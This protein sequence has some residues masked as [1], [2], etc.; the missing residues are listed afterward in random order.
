MKCLLF[1][2]LLSATLSASSIPDGAWNGKLWRKSDLLAGVEKGD[3]DAL[4]EWAFCA[5]RGL[6]ELPYD[7]KLIYQRA[8]KA[9]DLGSMAGKR[10]AAKC[11]MFG[12]GVGLDSKT[13]FRGI[14]RA[15]AQDCPDA[16]VDMALLH[17]KGEFGAQKDQAKAEALLRK[18]EK[19]GSF[20]AVDALSE[21]TSMKEYGGYDLAESRRLLAKAFGM[22]KDVYIAKK[23]YYAVVYSNREDYG[24]IITRRMFSE[25][26]EVIEQGIL[27]HH[28][29]ALFT[30]SFY[31]LDSPNGDRH[32]GVM[33]Q[34]RAANLGNKAAMKNMTRWLARGVKKR[35]AGE[36]QTLAVGN[37][38]DSLKTAKYAYDRGERSNSVIYVYASQLSSATGEGC[39]EKHRLAE[40]LLKKLI[41]NG[42]CNAHDVLGNLRLRRHEKFNGSKE[43]A[44][45]GLAHMVYH[46]N[47]SEY[48]VYGL[49]Y[50]LCMHKEMASYDLV[51]GA[52]ASHY[53]LEK[54]TGEKY[55]KRIHLAQRWLKAAEKFTDAQKKEYKR[56]VDA[57]FPA[58]E[59]YRR[60]AYE[61]LKK[62]GDLPTDWKF[63][64]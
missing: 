43:E 22:S 38:R 28:P 20:R 63:D 5:R 30:Q 3:A 12:I 27:L 49:V 31:E 53:Y 9:A 7:P 18:A 10:L 15:A 52:A 29:L 50:Y 4:A 62:A 51:K 54:F 1:A 14:E 37:Y 39:A 35:Y 44:E 61:L 33:L 19:E 25:A 34:I 17:L 26:R 46:S 56:L 59:L 6:M 16:W 48:A 21:L 36:Y 24:G 58:S 13:A 45:L 47:H 11:M 55:A 57:G 2:L 60:P 41:A 40:K 64:R 42:D 23:I 8:K 32:R